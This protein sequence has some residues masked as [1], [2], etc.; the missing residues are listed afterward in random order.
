M[1]IIRGTQDNKGNVITKAPEGGVGRVRC[2][3]C[4]MICTQVTLTTG[5]VVM[6]CGSCG[7]NYGVSSMNAS[8]KVI[9]GTV[10]RRPPPGS[11]P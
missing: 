5:Q 11:A 2:M 3:K 6:Q 9:P 7:S 8:P 10:P 1:R 4:Q